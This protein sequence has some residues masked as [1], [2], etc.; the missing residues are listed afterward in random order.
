M[1]CSM[2]LYA[3]SQLL[4]VVQ[5]CRI[6]TCTTAMSF[7]NEDVA[8]LDEFT[9]TLLSL[10]SKLARPLLSV[11]RLRHLPAHIQDVLTLMTASCIDPLLASSVASVGTAAFAP[12][13][14]SAAGSI[15]LFKQPLRPHQG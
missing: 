12:R 1:Q 8:R 14:C 10:S 15:R 7:D 3:V 6:S 13:R 9:S 11:S 2:A 4:K 5:C